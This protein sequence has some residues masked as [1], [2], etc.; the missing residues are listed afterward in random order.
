MSARKK[1]PPKPELPIP[2]WPRPYLRD[3]VPGLTFES[4]FEMLSALGLDLSDGKVWVDRMGRKRIAS[5]APLVERD[6][7]V[8]PVHFGETIYIAGLRVLGWD[9]L[10]VMRAAAKAFGSDCRIYCADTGKV[11]SAESTAPEM[12]EALTKAEEA[13]RR[14][15]TRGATDGQLSRRAARLDRGLAIAKR[16]WGG[17]LTVAVIAQMAK[18]STRTLYAHLPPR[19]EARKQAARKGQHA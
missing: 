13:R 16:E 4:Q 3:G 6:S 19:S 7:V 9:N 1:N 18:L 8:S 11:Y 10:D 15:R 17:P 5:R 2:G 14:A 12:L